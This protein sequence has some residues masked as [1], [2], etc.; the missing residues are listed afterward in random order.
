MQNIWDHYLKNIQ[1]L[2]WDANQKWNVPAMVDDWRVSSRFP[3]MKKKLLFHSQLT[4]II[5]KKVFVSEVVC[6]WLCCSNKCSSWLSKPYPRLNNLCQQS[7][8]NSPRLATLP[9]LNQV[10]RPEL[11]ISMTQARNAMFQP[12]CTI[13][14]F[15]VDFQPWKKSC[16]CTAS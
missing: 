11:C 4:T 7:A 15:L 6:V 8:I 9:Q 3:A 14:V 2:F 5:D 13:E 12:W 10:H 1:E 16:S